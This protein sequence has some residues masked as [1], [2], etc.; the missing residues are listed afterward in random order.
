[1]WWFPSYLPVECID[2]IR[3][4]E[5]PLVNAVLC[6]RAEANVSCLPYVCTYI[7]IGR[8]DGLVRCVWIFGLGM[9]HLHLS[10]H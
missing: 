8:A 5:P 4:G 7:I 9:Y 1:M 2:E 10:P 6:G 3:I